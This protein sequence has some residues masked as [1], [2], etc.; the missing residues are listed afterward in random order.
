MPSSWGLS[1]RL[2]LGGHE[3]RA[4]T[5]CG[6]AAQ[7]QD[8]VARVAAVRAPAAARRS[9]GARTPHAGRLLDRPPD[10]SPAARVAPVQYGPSPGFGF[11]PSPYRGRED[12]AAR[13]RARLTPSCRR[14]TGSHRRGIQDPPTA[15]A[16]S[17]APSP[18]SSRPS[19]GSCTT[20]PAPGT[21]GW[22]TIGMHE[23][24]PDAFPRAPPGRFG[25]SSEHTA[26]KALHP[27][28][29]A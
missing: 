25:G 29:P 11:C 8:S 27:P 12:R 24:A 20:Q 7:A 21:A 17:A 14:S 3:A 2:Q 5:M 16:T 4:G 10:R 13:D 6:N 9:P 15:V 26:A 23:P 22:S 19:T 28:G 1:T 18:A